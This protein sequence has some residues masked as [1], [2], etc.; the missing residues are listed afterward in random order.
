MTWTPRAQWYAAAT[1]VTLAGLFVAAAAAVRWFPCLGEL[2]G[3]G[4]IERQSRTYDYLV[5][6]QPWQGLPASAVLA[7]LGLL[8]LAASCL[9]VVRP[10]NVR[11]A[12][13][14]AMAGVLTAKP[15]LLGG[16]LLAAPTVGVLPRQASPVL[17]G[18]EIGLDIAAL[19]VLLLAPSYPQADYQRLLLAALAFWL[20]GWVGQVLDALIFGLLFPVAGTAPGSGLLTAEV[21]VGCGVAIA[22]ITRHTSERRSPALAAGDSLERP[23]HR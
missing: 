8:L 15:L 17:L 21:L 3:P 4:C 7:G 10:L 5:P 6:T 16:M 23:G 13:G 22:L 18:A 14:V 12:L 11:P 19:A 20:V 2:R 9:L 1:L